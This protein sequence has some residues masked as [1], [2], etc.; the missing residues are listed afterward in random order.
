MKQFLKYWFIFTFRIPFAPILPS[1]WRA[2]FDAIKKLI[3]YGC[4]TLGWILLTITLPVSAPSL[5]LVVCVIDRQ[6]KKNR[7]ELKKRMENR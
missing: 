4:M 5:A 2:M 1:N 6:A 3:F 7:E